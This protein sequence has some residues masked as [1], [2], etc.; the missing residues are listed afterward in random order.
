MLIVPLMMLMRKNVSANIVTRVP[1]QITNM[2]QDSAVHDVVRLRLNAFSPT[3][4][5][6]LLFLLCA[7]VLLFLISNRLTSHYLLT[8][9]QFGSYLHGLQIAFIS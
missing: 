5:S 9:N 2:I 4:P 6:S 1:L 3:F 8:N 7:A